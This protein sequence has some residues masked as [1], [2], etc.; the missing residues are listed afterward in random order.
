MAPSPGPTTLASPA[1][2][3]HSTST[4][5]LLPSEPSTAP[6]SSTLGDKDIDRDDELVE[7]PALPATWIQQGGVGGGGAGGRRRSSSLA[8]PPRLNGGIKSSSSDWREERAS[9]LRRRDAATSTSSSDGGGEDEERDELSGLRGAT[10]PRSRTSSFSSGA[11]RRDLAPSSLSASRSSADAAAVVNGHDHLRAHFAAEPASSSRPPSTFSVSSRPETASRPSSASTQRLSSRSRTGSGSLDAAEHDLRDAAHDD[12]IV[13]RDGKGKGKA[14]EPRQDPASFD[15][16]QPPSNDPLDP[17]FALSQ[18][19]SYGSF[20]PFGASPSFASSLYSA[21]RQGAGVV[22]PQGPPPPALRPPDPFSSPTP[23]P[24]SP[25]PLPARGDD[26]HRYPPSYPSTESLASSAAPSSSA[27]SFPSASTS[28]ARQAHQPS[29]QQLLQTVDLGAAL[30]LVQTLQTQQAQ[31]ARLA[32]IGTGTAANS[33]VPAANATIEPVSPL[34]A[35]ARGGPSAGG[36]GGGA[37]GGLAGSATVIDFA[38]LPSSPAA[39]TPTAFPSSS[40]GPRSNDAPPSPA[41]SESKQPAPSSRRTSLIGGL[42]RRLRSGSSMGLADLAGGEDQAPVQVQ[43]PPPRMTERQKEKRAAQLADEDEMARTLDDQ[44]SRVYLTL[45]PATL[46]RA[47][48]CARYLSLRYTPLFA[49]LSAPDHSIPLPNP[50]AVARWRAER[51]EAEKR[52]ARQQASASRNGGGGGAAASRFRYARAGSRSGLAGGGG[53]LGEDDWASAAG[54]TRLSTLGSVRS[55]AKPSPY[56]PRRNKAPK[57]W[58]LYPDDISDYVAMGGKATMVEAARALEGGAGAG[59]APQQAGASDG[60]APVREH[61]RGSM[62]IDELFPSSASGGGGGGSTRSSAAAV[63]AP[64][65][66]AKG[67]DEDLSRIPTGASASTSASAGA[68]PYL[69]NGNASARSLAMT[70]GRSSPLPRPASPVSPPQRPFQPRQPSYEGAPFA[71]SKH[72]FHSS[73]GVYPGSPLRRSTSLSTG[74]NGTAHPRSPVHPSSPLF[75]RDAVGL[76]SDGSPYSRGG[77][78]LASRDDLP[79][80]STA[81]AGVGAASIS[82]SRHRG[83]HSTTE[84][85]RSGI[86][87]RLDRIR[88][89]TMDEASA[90]ATALDSQAHDSPA[91]GR[92][93]SD[94]AARSPSRRPQ[95][96]LPSPGSGGEPGAATRRQFER[97]Y[98]RKNN[99]SVD[100]TRPSG[101]ESD[102]PMRSSGDEALMGGAAAGG[103]AW[104]RA[105]NRILQS[106]WQGFKTSLD[107]YPDPWGYPPAV[108]PTTSLYGSGGR[109]RLKASGTG[110]RDTD[111]ALRRS[112]IAEAEEEDD[113][114]GDWAA[115]TRRRRRQPREV[116]DLGEEDFGRLNSALR[117]VRVE[118]ARIDDSLPQQVATLGTCLDELSAHAKATTAEASI[119]SSYSS[120]RIPASV[121][122]DIAHVQRRRD[123]AE[124]DGVSGGSGNDSDSEDSDSSSSTSTSSSSSSS[125][126]SSYR[127]RGRGA[128]SRASSPRKPSLPA[129]RPRRDRHQ[130]QAHARHVTEPMS[131]RQQTRA[132]SHTLAF[133]PNAV[134]PHG[135]LRPRPMEVSRASGFSPMHHAEPLRVLE[136]VV[137][138]LTRAADELDA[139]AR[140]V[141]VEQDKVDAEINRL[142]KKV[143]ATQKGIEETDYQK[144]RALEDHHLRLRTRLARPSPITSL[145]GPAGDMVAKAFFVVVRAAFLAAWPVH[146]VTPTLRALGL[147]LSYSLAISALSIVALALVYYVAALRLWAL[148][149]DLPVVEPFKAL[150]VNLWSL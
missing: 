57:V 130:V 88:G 81:G 126:A 139:G 18:S 31:Q 53:A 92:S 7:H 2:P 29:L 125:R 79:L 3:P 55:G 141:A 70:D 12:S 149:P 135:A 82:T 106:A 113:S 93:D 117:Q 128:R 28:S 136:N 114:E 39:R 61:K 22:R 134:P 21:G 16:P 78:A 25:P 145:V 101:F 144:L 15:S 60:P 83:S 44:I 35:G 72:S 17:L 6:A 115:A 27:A 150:A 143:E 146:W 140:E 19:P 26:R 43:M 104:R 98:L 129:R 90:S 94:Y 123:L 133:P 107:T 59:S 13:A 80:S 11:R 91:Q 97:P 77:S 124:E 66:S 102:G 47:Q 137:R 121:L 147:P 103:K 67:K 108:R 46:R 76:A 36:S 74:P 50:L 99:T 118:V 116:V 148:L 131:A 41:L 23:V 30:K 109:G 89:R 49:A 63:V 52:S 120:P 75:G 33:A 34:A 51:D 4:R 1:P 96:P 9:A 20:A 105:S 37:A 127:E 38:D 48:N 14:R 110:G 45:S 58:E 71:R 69:R 95:P 122:A 142:V 84:A 32:T 8:V 86:S 10:R 112:Q 119:S 68:Q 64:A 62:S 73:D 40:F 56:G 138:D 132:R 42:Q 5:R 54:P 85:L 100:V 65:A 87:R 24:P 111:G